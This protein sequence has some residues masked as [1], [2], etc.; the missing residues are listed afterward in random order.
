MNILTERLR[1]MYR[2]AMTDTYYGNRLV[3]SQAI[4]ATYVLAR[5]RFL[6]GIAP[7]PTPEGWHAPA[8]RKPALDEV[9]QNLIDLARAGS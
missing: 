6:L 3:G 9:A 2:G 8:Y 1:M 4:E 5:M 7:E